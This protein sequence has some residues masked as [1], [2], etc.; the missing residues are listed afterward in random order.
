MKYLSLVWRNLL[1]KKVRTIFTLLSVLVAFVLFGYLSAIN[2]AFS[3]G[4]DV[5]GRDRLVVI[6]KISLIQPLPVSYQDRLEALPGVREAAHATW[7]GGKYQ[8]KENEFPIMAVDPEKFMS[9]Y[10]EFL[11]SE[12]QKKTW[13]ANRTGVMVGRHVAERFAWEI[14]D[15]IPIQGTIFRL[16]D[17]T[18]TWEFTVDAIYEGATKGVD[19]TQ[20]LIQFDYF[21]EAREFGKDLTGWYIVRIEDPENAAAMAK[22]IDQTF[23]N[24]FYETKTSTEKVFVEG[25]AKQIGDIGKI[26][27]AVLTAVFVTILLVA[28]NTMGQS[29]R[30][31][32]GE[33]AVL[34]TLGFSDGRVL[35]LVLAESLVLS[36]LGGGLGLALGWLLV[37]SG[38]P[39]NGLLP[40]FYIP[41]RDF[42]VGVGLVLILGLLSG[43]FPAFQAMR[44]RIVDAL[45]R[46]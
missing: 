19:E 32:T 26:L 21:N 27:S 42:A 20:F 43:V 30:E 7:F 25:F 24:S 45:R 36:C 2:L 14:G 16:A 22:L 46:G 44:L 37:Q 6:H 12:E 15:R 33:L 10:P 11:V 13:L 1:R 3:L 4:V 35:G 39:T 28:G 38:D 31:R 17:G 23:A 8:D 40:V 5:T 34:K 9:L 29:V 41:G 18:D